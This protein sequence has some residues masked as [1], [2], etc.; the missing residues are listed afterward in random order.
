MPL[1]DVEQG[2]KV[3]V[4]RFEN[5]A[6]DLLNYLKDVGLYPGLEGTLGPD[7]DEVTIEGAQKSATV[8]RSVAEAAS[9]FARP[10]ARRP[11]RR[12]ASSFGGDLVEAP[13]HAA[14]R[15]SVGAPTSRAASLTRDSSRCRR[16]TLFSP[17]TASMRRR[18]EPIEPFADDLDQPMSP[19]ARTWVPPHSSIE[20][21]GL[22]HPDD[23]AV[24]VAEERDGAELHR[25]RPW[26]SRRPHRRV[27]EDLAVGDPLDLGDL[28]V[29]DR[30]VVAE[31]E[32]QPIR[33]DERAG[34]LDVLA[35]HLAQ[36]VVQQVSAGVVAP[37]RGRAARRRSPPPPAARRRDRTAG[38]PRRVPT[39][40]RQRRSRVEHLGGAV[41]GIVPVSP[42][43]PPLSA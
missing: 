43:W 30:V 7:E 2:A 16:R 15:I 8:T 12:R 41:S 23:V 38:D 20:L 22:E 21:A 9:S 35:E 33:S 40:A 34:L 1:A 28:V 5:E 6:E 39:Q 3:R 11:R 13:V 36:R 42:T 26:W 31:V 25:P 19:V 17:V 10:D 14:E 24:L 18:F 37:D 27:G 32:A 29:G 4:L